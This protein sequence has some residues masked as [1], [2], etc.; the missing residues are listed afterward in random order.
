MIA[1]LERAGGAPRYTE[2]PLVMH[3]SWNRAWAEPGLARWVFAQSRA[4]TREA[5]NVP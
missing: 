4:T 2:Y 1:A 5:A 3:Q